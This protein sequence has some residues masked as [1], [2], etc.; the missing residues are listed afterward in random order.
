MSDEIE[1]LPDDTG[2][3]LVFADDEGALATGEEKEFERRDQSEENKLKRSIFSV[4]IEVTSP[5]DLPFP[6][7]SRQKG[8]LQKCV[9]APQTWRGYPKPLSLFPIHQCS[10]VPR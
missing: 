9:L 6:L 4:P 10:P 3:D 1:N 2:D 8:F 5:F 7:G